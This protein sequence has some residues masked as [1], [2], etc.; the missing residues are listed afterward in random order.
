MVLRDQT[1]KRAK[2]SRPA[3]K[4]TSPA[5][6]KTA[7]SRRQKIQKGFQ[8]RRWFLLL[9][10]VGIWALLIALTVLLAVFAPRYVAIGIVLLLIGLGFGLRSLVEDFKQVGQ[11][12]R[13]KLDRL[14]DAAFRGFQI[15]ETP[16]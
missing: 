3:A 9:R 13:E 15:K 6:D 2:E 1:D 7:S 16:K 4:V 5:E 11:K 12:E 14:E 8:R 10:M